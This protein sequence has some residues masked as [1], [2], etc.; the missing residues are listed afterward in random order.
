MYDVNSMTLKVK[1]IPCTK[2]ACHPPARHEVLPR[3]EFTMGIIAPKGS[4]KTTLI[5]NLLQFYKNYFHDIIIFS[6]TI[7]SDDKWDYVKQQ[8][9]VLDNT[10]LKNFV[11]KMSKDKEEKNDSVVDNGQKEKSLLEEIVD[12]TPRQD[13]KIGEEYFFTE[14]NEETLREILGE[15]KQIISALKSAGKSKHLANRILLIFDDLVGSSLFNNTRDSVFKT[16]N[17]NHRH[18][19]AS[20]LMVSQAYKEI[21]KT[22]RSNFSSLIIFE[23]P[24]DKELEV[25]YE[26]HT[27]HMK[28]DDWMTAYKHAT[29]EDHGFMYVNYQKPKRLRMM[30]KFDQVMFAE[31]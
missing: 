4:G 8:D 7:A 9:L 17:T 19:S 29:D 20:I 5:A 21:P 6:P 3:H 22:V 31:K 11:K 24:N 1:E 10:A 13:K 2:G 30:N 12:T 28:R 25:I 15:Q 27:L 18:L 16:L 26:E 14:Y 23:T